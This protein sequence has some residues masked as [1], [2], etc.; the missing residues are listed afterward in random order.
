MIE[1]GADTGPLPCKS[2]FRRLLDV[3]PLTNQQV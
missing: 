1:Q 2:D 3:L